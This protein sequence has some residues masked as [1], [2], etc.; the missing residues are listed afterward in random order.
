MM[1]ESKSSIVMAVF[2]LLGNS[3]VHLKEF[4]GSA[5]PCLSKQE[6]DPG[7]GKALNKRIT[8][9]MQRRILFF[10]V[11]LILMLSFVNSVQDVQH[12]GVAYGPIIKFGNEE[13]I[14][15]ATV[16]GR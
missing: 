12:D 9:S 15:R 16:F 4:L 10:L 13:K 1:D 8:D 5:L 2:T 14:D 7:F 6:P 11:L 3:F